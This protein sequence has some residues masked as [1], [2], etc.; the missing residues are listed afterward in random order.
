MT[1]SMSKSAIRSRAW[2]ERRR[3]EA[4]KSAKPKGARASTPP[5]R[6][7]GGHRRL[8]P[9]RQ[10]YEALRKDPKAYE[11]MLV[12]ARERAARFHARRKAEAR[13][14]AR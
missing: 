3:A 13:K 7:D 6:E 14:A 4:A 9:A 1:K 11:A 5:H 10:R 2:R 12:K 8:P